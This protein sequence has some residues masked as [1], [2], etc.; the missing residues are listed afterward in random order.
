MA[1]RK[2]WSQTE[3]EYLRLYVGL[4]SFADIGA[5]L[6][7][8]ADSAH[9]RSRKLGLKGIRRG[10]QHWNAKVDSLKVAMIGSLADAGFRPIEIH[11]LLTNRV[12]IS[13]KS[14]EDICSGR[15]W[16]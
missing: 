7:R 6:G 15:T 5:A 16:R 14:I 1:A 11:A 10:E 3:D 2:A 4:K 9:G 8:S 12:E 13:K